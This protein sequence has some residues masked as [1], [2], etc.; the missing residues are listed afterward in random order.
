[1]IMHAD[2]KRILPWYETVPCGSEA[3]TGGVVMG[4]G[5]RYVYYSSPQNEP[6]ILCG[7]H[8]QFQSWVLRGITIQLCDMARPEV[9]TPFYQSLSFATLGYAL[10]G[11]S[12]NA[13][14][15]LP[16]PI[17]YI[18]QPGHRIQVVLRAESAAILNRPDY[19]TFAGVRVILNEN[20][21]AAAACSN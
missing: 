21:K 14:P 12:S 5:I 1:M 17:P 19:L 18:I 15:V 6:L 13:E 11:T 10:P 8:G 16:L 20:E 9:W 2:I 4:A 7:F 3:V